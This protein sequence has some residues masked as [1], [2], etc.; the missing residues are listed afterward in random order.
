MGR[1]A[2]V[3]YGNHFS[4]MTGRGLAGKGGIRLIITRRDG[5]CGGNVLVIIF[6]G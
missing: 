3:L 1:S 4:I 5:A 2:G 6:V